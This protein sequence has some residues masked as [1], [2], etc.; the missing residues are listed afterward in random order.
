MVKELLLYKY[1]PKYLDDFEENENIKEILKSFIQIDIIKILFVSKQSNGK[2]SYIKALVNEYYKGNS[3]DNILHINNLKDYGIS[4]YKNEVQHFCK[5]PSTTKAKKMIILDDFDFMNEQCQHIFKNIIEKY[6]NIHFLLSCSNPQ[7]IILGIQSL[8][9]IIEIKKLDSEKMLNIF[10]RIKKNENIIVGNID[11]LNIKNMINTMEKHMLLD[12]ETKVECSLQINFQKYLKEIKSKN[13]SKCINI[14]YDLY[15]N[16]YSVI[17][18][19]YGFYEY[20]KV[21]DEP[22]RYEIIPFICKYINIF[23]SHEDVIELALFTHNLSKISFNINEH[24]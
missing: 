21:E 15:Y 20:I 16:G 17:D 14:F 8:M 24:F 22:L 1:E 13:I 19:L 12:M 9:H 3:H 2:S 4:F 18:I 6:S 10:N 7:K 11:M 23:Y 5:T